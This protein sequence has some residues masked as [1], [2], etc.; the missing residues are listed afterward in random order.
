MLI[1][2]YTGPVCVNEGCMSHCYHGSAEA[3]NLRDAAIKLAAKSE[4][5]RAHV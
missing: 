2:I 4:I 5:G 1:D 3:D